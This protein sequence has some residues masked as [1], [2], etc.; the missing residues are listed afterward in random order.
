MTDKNAELVAGY[1]GVK[2]DSRRKTYVVVVGA[3]L[4]VLLALGALGYLIVQARN[5]ALSNQ[6]Y[7][8]RSA[9]DVLDHRVSA[10]VSFRTIILAMKV[11]FI[12][13]AKDNPNNAAFGR[14]AKR[15]KVPPKPEPKLTRERDRICSEAG[16][17]PET[18]TGH[19][20]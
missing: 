4:V 11:P 10:R 19:G 15:I 12:A 9:C 7:A 20:S 3:L 8:A 5:E 16:V 17:D 13:A 18:L 6:R 14:A 2:R 1:A